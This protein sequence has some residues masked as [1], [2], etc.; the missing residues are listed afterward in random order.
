MMIECSECGNRIA[1]AAR[2]CP[3]CGYRRRVG[4]RH[5]F[6]PSQNDNAGVWWLIG[7]IFCCAP[8]LIVALIQSKPGSV[9]RILSIVFLVLWVAGFL[10]AVALRR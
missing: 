2:S 8:L 9:V 1:S 4:A 7:G 6:V 3:H 5:H 10:G